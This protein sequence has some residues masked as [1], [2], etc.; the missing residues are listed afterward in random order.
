[1]LTKNEIIKAK[2]PGGNYDDVT[3]YIACS[4]SSSA[5]TRHACTDFLLPADKEP[6]SMCYSK[7]PA[8]PSFQ[9]NIPFEPDETCCS[10]SPGTWHIQ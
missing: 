10:N 4:V 7:D 3:D 8:A 1:M 5:H 6:V 2:H 9:P